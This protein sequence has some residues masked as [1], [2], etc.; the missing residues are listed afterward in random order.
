M[1]INK[2]KSLK[3]I[4]NIIETNLNATVNR[5]LDF[6]PF[7]VIHGY[8][9]I[10]PAKTKNPI[11]LAG[12]RKRGN[13]SQKKKETS[14]DIGE[15]VLVRNFNRLKMEEHWK[16]P[17]IIQERTKSSNQ[18]LIQISPVLRLYKVTVHFR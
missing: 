7:E 5:V 15:E 17:G 13:Y 2:E 16:G 8:A 4:E 9:Q 18:F 6:T 10:D 3:E 11:D 12:I 1:R 14:L